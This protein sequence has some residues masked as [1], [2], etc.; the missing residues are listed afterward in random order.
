VS[1]LPEKKTVPKQ[2]FHEYM[3]VYYGSPGSGKTSVAAQNPNAVFIMFEDGIAGHSVFA[4]NVPRIA[5]KKGK[6]R[7]QVFLDVVDELLKG[8]HNFNE[9]VIDT[10]DRAIDACADYTKEREGLDDLSSGTYGSGWRSLF[11][12]F[13]KPIE[14]LQTSELG[15][16]VLSHGKMK[17]ITDVRGKTHDK[18]IANLTGQAGQWVLDEA[19][20]VLLFDVDDEDN[21]VM[22]VEATKN[23]DAKQRIKFPGGDISMGKS[24]KEAYKNLIDSF[25]K[26][27]KQRNKELGITKEQIEEYYQDLEE[28]KSKKSFK[29]LINDIAA[30]CQELGLSK[31]DNAKEMKEKYGTPSLGKLT[32]EQAQDRV[33]ELKSRL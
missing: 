13:K 26:A 24:E 28:F 19:D 20:I 29:D 9:V 22:R 12:N 8:E 30:K 18:I 7:W 21:R 15:L 11:D 3:K 27:V 5:K 23:F 17:E 33:E 25:E 6:G 1:L 16:S 4:V 31:K 2:N 14:K 10:A 32:Y